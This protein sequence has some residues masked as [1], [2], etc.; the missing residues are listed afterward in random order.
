MKYGVTNEQKADGYHLGQIWNREEEVAKPPQFLV[1]RGAT[2]DLGLSSRAISFEVF[3]THT[4]ISG[5]FPFS[6]DPFLLDFE[7]FPPSFLV[8]D[9]V[10]WLFNHPTLGDL[11]DK[12][13]KSVTFWTYK[14]PESDSTRVVRE[15]FF[16]FGLLQQIGKYFGRRYCLISQVIAGIY[17]D[18]ASANSELEIRTSYSATRKIYPSPTSGVDNFAPPELSTEELFSAD[19]PA[20][21]KKKFGHHRLTPSFDW[22]SLQGREFRWVD[23]CQVDL[24]ASKL[25]AIPILNQ[26]VPGGI[27]DIITHTQ[28][29]F[30]I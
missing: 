10:K 20:R 16:S 19:Y 25:N 30:V 24:F 4:D 17:T 18:L 22:E 15:V 14:Y 8:L 21:V 29:P 6:T 1:I 9:G 27:V 3:F 7:Q 26:P 2:K 11:F 28:E 13:P 12:E 5:V 23:Y